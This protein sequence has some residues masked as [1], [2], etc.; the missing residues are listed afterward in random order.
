[1]K[2]SLK[3][4]E[5]RILLYVIGLW[6]L[7]VIA[8]F[9][10]TSNQRP[11]DRA[12]I[13]KVYADFRAAYLQ[14]R[15]D[16]AATNYLSSDL[17]SRHPDHNEFFAM[18][19]RVPESFPPLEHDAYVEFNKVDLSRAVIFPR[20]KAPTIGRGLVKET[21]GWKIEIDSVPVVPLF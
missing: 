17:L 5:W 3:D 2:V 13:K 1:M 8:V 19:F 14:K 12:Q 7:I 4:K 9:F 21:N 20:R 6:L 18:F 11:K 10:Y 15:Y 16:E